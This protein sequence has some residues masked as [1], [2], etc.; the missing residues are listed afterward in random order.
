MPLAMHY[1]E[2]LSF[3]QALYIWPIQNTFWGWKWAQIRRSFSCRGVAVSWKCGDEYSPREHLWASG[4]TTSLNMPAVSS[5]KFLLFGRNRK[6]HGYH[7]RHGPPDTLKKSF[8]VCLTLLTGSRRGEQIDFPRE[9]NLFS[10]RESTKNFT[11]QGST[12]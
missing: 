1:S 9:K 7:R 6:R 3:R 11:N 5:P 4:L 10:L 2:T 12:A 8:S